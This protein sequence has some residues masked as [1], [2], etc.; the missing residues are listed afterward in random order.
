MGWQL[1]QARGES[2]LAF[3]MRRARLVLLWALSLAIAWAL[4]WPAFPAI[5]SHGMVILFA[6]GMLTGALA[7]ATL[8]V[9]LFLPI[10]LVLLAWCVLEIRHPWVQ[11]AR[12]GVSKAADRAAPFLLVLG[13]GYILIRS[14]LS[15]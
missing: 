10:V 14:S 11:R 12:I 6:S 8:A 2:D 4:W 1:R 13:S 9:A 5:E 15:G 3:A 7:L